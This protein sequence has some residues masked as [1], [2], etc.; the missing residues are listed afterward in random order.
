[1]TPLRLGTRGSQLALAQTRE[2]A[3]ALST[4]HPGLEIEICVVRTTGD[5]RLDADLSQPGMLGKGLFTKQLE[6]ALVAQEVDV[7]VHSLKDLP[8]EL[9]PGLVLGAIP[10]RADPRDLLFSKHPGGL[11]A[12]PQG[13]RVGTSSP[14]RE[15][16]LKAKR[17]DLQVL[18]MRG[19]VP[20]RMEKLAHPSSA[21]DAIVLAKAGWDRLGLAAPP[22]V[23]AEILED[24]LPAPGQGALG[25][26]CR[27][28]DATTLELLAA[29]HHEP[30]AA[31][32]RAERELL[33]A[34]GGGCA[35]PVGALAVLT[36][37]GILLRAAIFPSPA[38]GA[39]PQAPQ[40]LFGLFG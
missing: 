39:D 21:W 19:N 2:V 36:P 27:S 25:L 12:L 32:V 37:A 17:P 7:A 38:A 14:R 28:D 13:A 20:T 35:A 23:F 26:E 24:F 9:P 31:C 10:Q 3:A 16:L 4:S 15:R 29:I 6:E 18:P 40:G 8:V 11:S 22:G 1:M 33:R 34:L 5:E 30:T